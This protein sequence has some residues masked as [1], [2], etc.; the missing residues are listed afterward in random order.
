MQSLRLFIA[1]KYS[2]TVIIKE[3]KNTCWI[4]QNL[5]LYCDN[6]CMP[7]LLNIFIRS[8]RKCVTHISKEKLSL[9][10]I[11]VDHLGIKFRKQDTTAGTGCNQV[12][13]FT[14]KNLSEVTL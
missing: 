11:I 9:D 1:V 6:F 8:W 7:V 4:F 14:E 12:V 2:V 3:E 10:D 13:G 5:T